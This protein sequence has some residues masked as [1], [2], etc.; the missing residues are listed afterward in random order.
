MT[1]PVCG[2]ITIGE[3]KDTSSGRDMRSVICRYCRYME[4]VDLDRGEALSEDL[5]DAH[6][7]PDDA[8]G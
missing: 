3:E 6:E 8:H 2:E 1:C 5:H 4:I 7:A